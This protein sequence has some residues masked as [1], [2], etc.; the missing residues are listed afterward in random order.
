MRGRIAI[1]VAVV[2]VLAL[3]SGASASFSGQNGKLLLERFD[4]P[5][6]KCLWTVNPDGTA[7]A[8]T[9]LCADTQSSGVNG[10]RFRPD[11]THV[12]YNDGCAFG[13]WTAKLDGT[14]K[15][16]VEQDTICQEGQA[17]SPDGQRLVIGSHFF[18]TPDTSQLF[19]IASGGGD[20]QFLFNRSCPPDAQCP[21]DFN[22]D[23]SP[24]GAEIL[25]DNFGASV[26]RIAAAGGSPVLV[27]GGAH[28]TWSP[29]ARRIAFAR[30]G[31]TRTMNADATGQVNITN[32]AATDSRPVWSPDG[33]KIAFTS[34]PDGN[35]AN[36]AVWTMNTDG[37][38]AFQV[39]AGALA[40][41]QP[42]PYTGYPRPRGAT[43]LKA[44][45]VIA[46][47]QCTAPNSSHG[48]GLSAPSCAP[49]SQTS[50]YLTVG[51][52][53]ANG[54]A[55]STVG[56]VTYKTVVGNLSTPANDADV[57]I[58]V[59]ITG[60]LTKALTPYSGELRTDQ[61]LRITDRNNSPGT[62]PAT[63][64]EVS[65]PATVP[66]SAGTCTTLTTANTLVPGA[67]LE[68]MR[69]IWEVGPVRVYDGGADGDADT[70]ADNTLFMDQGVFI[71]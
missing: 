63:G 5:G 42:I 58:E 32:S 19:T 20:Q 25:Y 43:P 56:T 69:A 10:A 60:V 45:L 70:T 21:G 68:G 55:P 6:V 15:V 51:T 44:P 26:Y 2:A 18:D 54:L 49:P 4:Q 9:A 65:L 48:G 53:D 8:V 71:P 64:Q 3:P 30:G 31:D 22:P 16:N 50:D 37:S 23:W 14:D 24:S 61:T 17:W 7:P 13:V 33:K 46:Y 40:D 11:G 36:N 29:D 28:A 39:A 57:Q 12:A 38:G 34:T 52:P 67:V 1:A 41:W 62:T 27:T 47:D 59:A 35:G 66:C